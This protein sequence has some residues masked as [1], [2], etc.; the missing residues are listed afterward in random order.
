MMDFS[1]Q[2]QSQKSISIKMVLDF[3][4]SFG[5]ENLHMATSHHVG[6][7]MKTENPVLYSDGK[8]NY[9]QIK[10]PVLGEVSGLN[11]SNVRQLPFC[12]GRTPVLLTSLMANCVS[13]DR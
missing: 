10:I 11:L 7:F 5:R 6:F 3:W 12:H 13:N 8:Y 4:D 1:F 9:L 2:K